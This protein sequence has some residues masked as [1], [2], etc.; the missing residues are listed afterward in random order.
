MLKAAID[1]TKVGTERG[2]VGSDEEEQT[3]T[4]R[5]NLYCRFLDIIRP[6]VTYCTLFILAF[7]GLISMALVK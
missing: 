1:V 6:Y 7:V 5:A 2:R 3:K 4:W